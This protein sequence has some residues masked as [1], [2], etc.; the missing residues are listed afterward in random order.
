MIFKTYKMEEALESLID[1][2]G[3]T[4][5]KSDEGIMTLSAK[6]VRDGY[7]DYS[8]CYYISQE[9]YDRFMVRGFP[10][11]GD[12]LMTTEA[13]LG[14]TA[15]LDRDDVALA[16]RLLTLRGKRGVL[17]TG[18]L[19][20]YLRSP[21]GQ[22]KLLERQTGTTVTGIKQAE[23]RKIEI[24]LPSVDIQR[25]VASF[26]ETIDEK[27]IANKKINK[28]LYEQLYLSFKQDYL[29]VCSNHPEWVSLTLEDLTDKFATGLNPRKNFVLGHGKNYYV[30]IKNM[31]NNRIYLN[32][33]CDKVDDDALEKINK[34]SDLKP[35]DLLFSGIGTIGRT[36]LIDKPAT[37]WNISESVFTIRPSSSVSSEFLFLL[38]LSD[39][40][41]GYA[42]SNSSGSV[43][44]GI[45]M[46]DLKK[47]R[48]MCPSSNYMETLTSRWRPMI[49][50]IKQNE[51]ESDFLAVLRD[52]LLPK[53]MS[54]E[55]DIS[56]VVV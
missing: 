41:Q 32:D 52:T 46:A 35:G 30:T 21:L 48:V 40:M 5:Q 34:R 16:Q 15:R 14:V 9:E 11:I 28:N 53:L 25:K 22:T 17:D 45:R 47:Y 20:Y 6:S 54:G 3:K 2:R 8:Q 27:I 7:I 12:V 31:L 42:I 37:N 44:K 43:Q 36:Y 33:K 51:D 55:L 13:P 19:Y 23:F 18:Y 10:K 56:S 39:E 26:L 50:L 29:E 38:L 4:P 24:D 1:Y 49:S